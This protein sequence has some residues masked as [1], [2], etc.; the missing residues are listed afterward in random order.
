MTATELSTEQEEMWRVLGMLQITV[1][2]R[3]ERAVLFLRGVLHF[4][5]EETRLLPDLNKAQID[6]LYK[7]AT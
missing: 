7:F 2:P 1:L 6:Q 3:P 4:S 5:C